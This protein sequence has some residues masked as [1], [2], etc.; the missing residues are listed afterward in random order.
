MG[1]H[2]Q[3]VHWE[4]NQP[5][6]QAASVVRSVMASDVPRTPAGR[7]GEAPVHTSTTGGG[8]ACWH[9]D[10]SRSQHESPDA[11]VST[12]WTTEDESLLFT[13]WGDPAHICWGVLE[14]GE[15]PAQHNRLGHPWSNALD[16]ELREGKCP[17]ERSIGPPQMRCTDVQKLAVLG[18]CSIHLPKSAHVPTRRNFLWLLGGPCAKS[19]STAR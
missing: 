19:S 14:R 17:C 18:G 10:R 3:A 12:E 15:E 9:G 4:Q 13:K 7:S 8:A 6:A 1:Q 5:G 2:F 16:V 11:S